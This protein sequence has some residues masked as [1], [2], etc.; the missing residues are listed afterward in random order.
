MILKL[1]ILGAAGYAA[2]CA[3]WQAF[4]LWFADFFA[5]QN[6]RQAYLL[7]PWV[8]GVALAFAVIQTAQLLPSLTPSST[9]SS[10]L[11]STS[12]GRRVTGRAASAALVLGMA[13]CLA[14]VLLPFAGA[15]WPLMVLTIVPSFMTRTRAKI[16]LGRSTRPLR[17]FLRARL[18]G[19][20]GSA[21]FSGILD[22]WANP[23]QPGQILLGASLYDPAWK[24]GIADD[25][26]QITIATTRAGKGRSAIIPNLL[27]WPGS[28]L[29]IDPKGQNAVVTALAR[30]DGGAGLSE[31]L[32]QKVRIVDPLGAVADARLQKYIAR[33]NPLTELVPS[34]SD[35]IERIDM[36]TD[37]LV[38]P[39]VNTKDN[40]FESSARAIISAVI[41]YAMRSPK[42]PKE[43]RHLGTVRELLIHPDGLP[44][45]EM[46]EM[47]GLAQAGAA[48]VSRAGD[49]AAG[50]VQATAITNTKWLD[51]AGMRRTLSASD[52]SL[53][54]LN[55]GDTTVY[56]V[57]PP[58]Y[59]DIHGQFLRLFV[60]TALQ[61]APAEPNKEHATLYVLD[62][63]YALGRLQQISKAAGLMAGYG[64]KLWPFI[65]NIGQVEELYPKNW[66][67]L[68]GNA[69]QWQVFA[70]NDATT[71]RYL[72][73]R[74]GK[75]VN[76]RKMRGPNGYSWEPAGAAHLRDPLEFARASSRGSD[77]LVVFTA[78][79]DAFLLKRTPYD[80]MFPA[81]RYTPDPFEAGRQ[82]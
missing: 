46:L 39:D 14:G 4:S 30:G 82:R 37:A 51:S 22:E 55:N 2:F 67:S 28:A 43:D 58:Q 23:W 73:E 29:V 18:V 44:I 63:F 52:F 5:Y 24:I 8:F 16:A 47:G 75:R 72:S 64:V 42:V 77:N 68:L 78:E 19:L 21:N 13:G 6:M 62:E 27:T 1:L 69:G 36:I 20:G 76:W 45:D 49:N 38:V 41:D 3:Y 54:D 7:G 53:R 50:D 79:G 12:F 31:S 15:L 40:F 61:E 17:R 66:E 10:G 11:W 65:Q 9:S 81:D 74:L 56:L 33:F 70:V 34:A 57:L 26:H 48:L 32:G 71:A 59:I 80:K 60:Q 35:Y 25:R